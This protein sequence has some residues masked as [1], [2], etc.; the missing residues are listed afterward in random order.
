MLIGILICI[1]VAY[2][3]QRWASTRNTA[4]FIQPPVIK[5]QKN[6]IPVSVNFHFT[7]RCNY[8]CGFCYH[9]AKSSDMPNITDAKFALKK[10]A[11]AGMRK[12]NFAGGEPFLYPEYLG[13]LVR[14]CKQDLGLESVSIV[15]NG[16]RVRRDWFIHYGKYLDITAVSCDS[17]NEE[18]NKQIGRGRG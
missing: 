13:K 12:L 4:A 18:T 1:Y 9:T 10:L 17:F 6:L 11:D 3:F 8:E 7:R 15:T 2:L 5:Y 14:F 16:S